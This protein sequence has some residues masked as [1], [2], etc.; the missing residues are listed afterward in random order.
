MQQPSFWKTV[1]SI[2]SYVTCFGVSLASSAT[3]NAPSTQP[4]QIPL[5][6]SISPI[7]GTIPFHY[8]GETFQTFYKVFGDVKNKSQTP[9]VVLHGGPGLTHDY[10]IPISDLAQS[11]NIPVIFY[12]QIGN[13]RSTHLRE[14]P[15]DFWSVHLFVEELDNLLNF[16]QIHKS[17][18][19]LG[20]SWGGEL[21]AEFAVQKPK[22]LKKLILSDAPSSSELMGESVFQLLQAFPKDIQ[23]AIEGGLADPQKYFAAFQVF[24]AV[25]GCTVVPVPGPLN[26]SFLAVFGP[27]GDPTVASAPFQDTWTI[28]DRIPLIHA[29]TLLLNGKADQVQDF[30]MQPYFDGISAVKWRTFMASSHTPFWEER[31]LYMTTVSNFLSEKR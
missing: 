31:E 21:A 5:E 6:T 17:F 29:P 20:H 19:L 10:L 25:H 1:L 14:K 24:S 18:N 7:N 8:Q 30:V 2:L 13:G 27:D 4:S 15:S 9:L 11:G 28:I 12:D 22:G 23:D 3:T 26:A 16:F